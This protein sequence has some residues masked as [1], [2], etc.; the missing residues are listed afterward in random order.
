MVYA[1]PMWETTLPPRAGAHFVETFA[2]EEGEAARTLAMI[3][4][5]EEEVPALV[6]NLIN[7]NHDS[8]GEGLY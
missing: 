1:G 8:L 3:T 4:S 2:Y 7:V 6:N 5:T